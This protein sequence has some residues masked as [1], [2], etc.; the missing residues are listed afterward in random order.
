M[1]ECE[2]IVEGG[3]LVDGT[4]SRR[5]RADVGFSDGRIVDV[6]DLAG[7]R[8]ERRIDAAGLIVAPGFIDGHTHDDQKLIEE[9]DLTPKVS[10]GV[11][12]VVV[13]NCGIGLPPLVPKGEPPAPLNLLGGPDNFQFPSF[14]AYTDRLERNP[15]SINAAVL[16]GHSALRATVMD[17]L[18]RPA[19]TEE[20]AEM[21][22]LL[23]EALEAGCIG[24]STGLA[25]ATA[26]AA[27]AEEVTALAAH[28]KPAGGLFSIHVRDEGD[29]L[30]DSI[31]ETLA[32]AK[33]SDVP[34]VI[35]HH[36][37]CA[38]GNWG[39]TE[40]TL[41]MIETA[42][43]A[44]QTVDL[45]TYPYTASST[46]LIPH[47][48]ARAE[49]TV[50]SWSTPHPEMT[51]RDLADI[52]EEW[53]LTFEET[54][55]RLLPAGA[56]YFQMDEDDLQRILRYPRTMIG[57]DGLPHDVRPHPRL[58]GAFARV[59]GHYVRDEGVLT[60]EDA[61]H[62]MTGIPAQV[63]GLADRGSLAS[64]KAADM[65]LFDAE[66]VCDTA[67]YDDPR[68]P[69]RGISRV[70]VNGTTVWTGGA[71]TGARPKRLLKRV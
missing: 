39:K 29:H 33:A 68:K 17:D 9:P 19:Y 64:G 40:K 12:T 35:S 49:R 23:D 54:I 46:I 1:K 43:Q 20:I 47:F 24:F 65:V 37:A 22:K 70:I 8:C 48:A 55:Q 28:L 38:R 30:I 62:R 32:I 31:A 6:G 36:K 53:G 11:T 45:D 51:G 63:Y 16:A 7:W 34:V 13:G 25:Y 71:H 10:Q 3:T 27:P 4:G 44:G 66:T 42:R 2:C 57:S 26:I 56:I 52:V 5:V 15:A 14:A 61:V 69:A 18:S 41:A 59:L 60:L 50:I 67:T 21:G 58:W